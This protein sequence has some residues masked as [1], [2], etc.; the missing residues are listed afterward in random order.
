MPDCPDEIRLFDGPALRLAWTLK[1]PHVQHQ[2]IHRRRHA[3]AVSR[4]W[5]RWIMLRIEPE[6]MARIED[7]LDNQPSAAQ[8]FRW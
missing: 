3:R 8:D 1:N 7:I 2:P 5:N 6:L 4:I